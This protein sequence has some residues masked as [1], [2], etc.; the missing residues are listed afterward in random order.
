[1]VIV[2]I[3][4]KRLCVSVNFIYLFTYLFTYL[5]IYLFV[6]LFIYLFICL[7]IYLFIYLTSRNIINLRFS[8]NVSISRSLCIFSCPSSYVEVFYLLYYNKE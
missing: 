6:H 8:V 5:I 2:S 7:F 3:T 4:Y 1:M